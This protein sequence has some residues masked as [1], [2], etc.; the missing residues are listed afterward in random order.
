MRWTSCLLQS[1]H[2]LV[3]APGETG[4]L[5]VLGSVPSTATWGLAMQENVVPGHPND[6]YFEPI[7]RREPRPIVVV[8]PAEY[9][10]VAVQW[11]SPLW[12]SATWRYARD[13]VAS[14]VAIRAVPWTPKA[15]LLQVC[16]LRGFFEL[17]LSSLTCV[18]E[19]TNVDISPNAS[20]FDVLVA[21]LETHLPDGSSNEQITMALQSRLG[22][23]DSRGVLSSD[24]L[25]E[26]NETWDLMDKDDET[27]RRSS[28]RRPTSRHNGLPA[29]ISSTATPPANT[30][31]GRGDR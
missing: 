22:S 31:C 21:L 10:A 13:W 15:H 16:E 14:Q 19:H 17:S 4:W 9:Q 20:L 3:R 27:R 26:I 12:Q 29:Q 7:L 2:L 1:D 8:N 28:G 5:L 18:A 25:L 30:G 6:I 24:T 11:R 23:M